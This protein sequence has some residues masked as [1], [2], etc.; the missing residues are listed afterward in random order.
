VWLETSVEA[1]DQDWLSPYTAEAVRV[2]GTQFNDTVITADVMTGRS[3]KDLWSIEF[4][5]NQG[6]DVFIGDDMG[7]RVQDG[8]GND[9]IIGGG[10]PV[11]GNHRWFG[12]DEVNFN[13]ARAR[14]T[15]EQ[16]Q[17][18]DLVKD[19]AGLTIYDLSQL[20]AGTITTADG[21]A[22][23][24]TDTSGKVFVVRDLM[25]DQ[26]EGNGINLL[27]GVERVNFEDGGINLTEEIYENTWATSDENY[28][29]EIHIRGTIYDDIINTEDTNLA[30]DENVYN[31]IEADDGNDYIFAGG[32]GDE[33]HPGKGN[34]FVDG[35][36]SGTEGDSWQRKDKVHIDGDKDNFIIS[37]ANQ[38]QV[39][40]FWAQNFAS[41]SFT[42]NNAQS[43]FLV[44][45][46]N[47]VDGYGSNLITN[48]DRIQFSHGEVELQT[49]VRGN[50]DDNNAQDRFEAEGTQFND[51]FNASTILADRSVL[52]SD[53]QSITDGDS[54]IDL[55]G[56]AG[57]DVFI[58][59]SE[60]S[61]F[62]GGTGNDLLVGD[63]LANASNGR[64]E[65]NFNQNYSRYEI[66]VVKAGDTVRQLSGDDSSQLIY[67]LS[68]LASGEITTADGTVHQVGSHHTQAYLVRDILSDAQGG[69]GVDLLFGVENISFQDKWIKLAPE[70][71]ENNG[72]S[73]FRA[74]VEL[75]PFDDTLDMSAGVVTD[76]GNTVQAGE[77]RGSGGN[78]TVIGFKGG[79]QFTGGTGSDVFIS[80]DNFEGAA[81][82]WHNQNQARYTG[83]SDRYQI[84]TGYIGTN[85][86]G[87]PNYIDG[88]I[89]WSSSYKDSYQ[90]AIKVTDLLSDAL[91]GEGTDYLIGVHRIQFDG[92]STNFSTSSETDINLNDYWLNGSFQ[93]SYADIG[94]KVESAKLTGEERGSR[95]DDVLTGKNLVSDALPDGWSA[96]SIDLS[97]LG[98]LLNG[99]NP[100][101][102]KSTNAGHNIEEVKPLNSL[103]SDATLS[104]SLWVENADDAAN[105]TTALTSDPDNF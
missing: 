57:D 104:A 63:Q 20:A 73:G 53:R 40:Q 29:R 31:R 94:Q 59:G 33:I 11:L 61:H 25:P 58:G 82:D 44:V 89:D 98:N 24:I 56:H 78:D 71:Y 8:A 35:G 88:Q 48:I 46:T 99:L 80:P 52:P 103:A 2:E 62:T 47:P 79:T 67:D 18:G 83:S 21:T 74:N 95:F 49:F 39:E 38:A 84:E 5:G 28:T 60:T 32:G 69:D 54:H 30:N 96:V 27:M 16:Y 65:V 90:T 92:D 97:V 93:D 50:F 86:E 6:D 9:M 100:V 22:H 3:A 34:D 72:S 77:I 91:G 81:N 45:D 14:Y 76:Q 68:A 15:I 64:D 70:V 37:E 66:T 102:F 13:G 36:A 43:Y 26:F 87:L 19:S 4:T 12:Q 42:Y 10:P 23:T 85:S 55:Q 105:I 1:W 75:T 7:S 41:S 51:T 101:L 17:A